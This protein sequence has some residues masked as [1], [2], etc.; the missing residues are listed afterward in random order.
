MWTIFYLRSWRQGNSSESIIT[1]LAQ[2]QES[3]TIWSL[4]YNFLTL[5]HFEAC[6]FFKQKYGSKCFYRLYNMIDKL[7]IIY[8]QWGLRERF[9][10]FKRSRE[11]KEVPTHKEEKRAQQNT[12]IHEKN[13]QHKQRWIK[14]LKGLSPCINFLLQ[15]I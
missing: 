15:F 12:P 3:D 1:R 14:H 9:R 8:H 6:K 10:R 2:I 13:K 7:I 5:T 4:I 11:K